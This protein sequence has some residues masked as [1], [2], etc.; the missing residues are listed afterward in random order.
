MSWPAYYET[1][2]SGELARRVE[3]ALASLQSCTVCP[4][5]CRIDRLADA[6]KLCH[7]GRRARVSTF[8]PH[9]GEED[10][11]RGH[12]GSGTIFFAWCNLKCVFCQNWET[13]N[14]GQ[15][16]EVDA[17]DLASMML[18][19]QQR[20]CHNIN[21]VTPEHVVPQVLEAL[22][23]AIEAGLNVPIVY[24]TSAY[25]SLRL[26]PPDGR[27]R[28]T[29]TCPH[30]KYWDTH[31]AA[32]YLKA[33][34]YPEVARAAIAEMHRQVGSLDIDD[35][36]LARRGVLVRHLVMPDGIEDTKQILSWLA[37][38]APDTYVN[39]MDQYHPDG[40][41]IREPNKFPELDR[42]L[43]Q[44]E[45]NDALAAAHGKGLRVDTR[46]AFLPILR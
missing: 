11:L 44:A 25:D 19:L 1:H 41:V 5:D 21:F 2:R 20:G 8:F 13:S 31:R 9:F 16:I 17:R 30:F 22:P 33:K 38:L 28:G 27:H 45:H 34:D 36:G 43:H 7:T 23:Y 18:E 6:R 32:R 3:E 37:D 15:G 39:V 42:R 14:E 26:P 10:C 46:R 29:S 35:D 40:R 12:R 24:N 4:R